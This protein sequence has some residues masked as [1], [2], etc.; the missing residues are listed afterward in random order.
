[1][2]VVYPYRKNYSNELF[3]SVK[4]LKNVKHDRVYII[5]DDPDF[6]IDAEI[7]KPTKRPWHVYSPFHD[8]IDKYLTACEISTAETMLLMNDD[9][10]ILEP[11]DIKNYNRGTLTEHLNIR[12]TDSYSS[13]L[14]STKEI[15]KN[16]GE[17][18][19]ELHIPMLVNRL[20]LKQ[21]IEELIPIISTSKKVM[22]RS[23]YGNRF[24]IESEFMS[25]IK[26]TIASPFMST[27]EDTFLGDL[28][29]HIRNKLC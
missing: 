1:M 29:E 10:F 17:L 2:D 22:I 27:N 12:A 19:F 3:W 11:T 18:D 24:N 8:Q 5:G 25:D 15:C 6:E 23:Y 9:F 21:A 7:I 16:Y 13:G 14:R 4:S 26:N 28:G 20:K